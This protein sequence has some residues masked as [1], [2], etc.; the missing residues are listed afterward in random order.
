MLAMIS[1]ADQSSTI[2]VHV[3]QSIESIF[4]WC[5]S[6]GLAL[7]IPCI[8]G[9]INI[10]KNGCGGLMEDTIHLSVDACITSTGLIIG[11]HYSTL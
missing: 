4:V 2:D 8:Y 6:C 7:N 11:K 10:T 3:Q 9:K 5:S 1:T